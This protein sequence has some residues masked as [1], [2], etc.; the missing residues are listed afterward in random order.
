MKDNLKALSKRLSKHCQLS[1][2]NTILDFSL[3]FW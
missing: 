3:L 1:I 2:Q